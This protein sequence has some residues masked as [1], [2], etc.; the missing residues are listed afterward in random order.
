MIA[1][2]RTPMVPM[3][4]FA[5]LLAGLAR[6]FS[7]FG[8]GLIF[9]PIASAALGPRVAVASLLVFDF[10]VAGLPVLRRIRDIEIR[11][12][13][14]IA[15]GIALFTPV[16]GWIAAHG[17]PSTIRWCLSIAVFAAVAMLTAGLKWPGREFLPIAFAVGALSGVLGGMASLSGIVVVI[18]WLGRTIEPAVLRRNMFTLLLL[19]AMVQAATFALNGMLTEHV[20]AIALLMLVP[21][22]I[23][24]TIGSLAFTLASPE[25]FR[26]IVYV[27]ILGS[28]LV[29][30]P[31]FD[32]WLGR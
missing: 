21:Y 10:L 23:G 8:S 25:T 1:Q 5:A 29:G 16:G 12:L 18:Y 7:G 6:G 32:G 20:F 24:T 22:V 27:M 19:T 17:D 9:M 31:L 3:A 26:R 14:P 4:L 30:L 15:S 28:G 11:G 2:A 13:L